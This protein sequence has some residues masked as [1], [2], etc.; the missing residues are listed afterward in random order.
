MSAIRTVNLLW[1]QRVRGLYPVSDYA[2]DNEG[3]LTLAMP[4]PLEPRAYDLTRRRLDGGVEVRWGFAVE[5]L[6]KMEVAS[7]S[8]DCLGMTSDDLYLFHAGNKSKFLAEKRIT[9]V[10]SALSGD[11]QRVAAAF[12][13]IAGASFALAYGEIGGRLTWLREFDTPLSTVAIARDGGR[14]AAGAENGNVWLLDSARRDLW[15]FLLD[16]PVRALACS[17]DGLAT[18]Y[19]T[20]GGGVGLIVGDGNRRWEARIAG[21]IVA[22]AL[23]SDGSL[24][25]ALARPHGDPSGT[26][27]IVCF[28]EDGQEGWHYETEKRLLGVALSPDGRYLATGARDGTTTVYAV[29]PGEGGAAGI[30]VGTAQ[31]RALELAQAGALAEACAVLRE[32]V[33]LQPA[34]LA[35][36]DAL[37]QSRERYFAETLTAAKGALETGDAG[38]AIRALAALL[39]EEPLHFEAVQML[40][41]AR[42]RRSEQ[43]LAEAH[44]YETK[45][46]FAAVESALREATAVAPLDQREPRQEL[47]AFLTRRTQAADAEAD[48]L[49]KAGETEAALAALERAQAVAASQERAARIV[50]AQIDLEFAEGMAAYNAKRYTEAIFQ[51]KKVLIR[52]PNHADARRYLGF[53]QKFAQDAQTDSLTDRFSR[54]E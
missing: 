28:L 39:Q 41:Q 42:R 7:A 54:L 3:A 23:S 33:G 40:L 13:D 49:L 18:A 38:G 53:A 5:T 19:G 52:D 24:C 44:V 21:E 30:A 32:A 11:G 31:A 36:C 45:E 47:A 50:R 27:W 4:R 34:D 9:Y 17:Q 14:V 29:V 43:L 26:T 25:T 22:V 15:T 12:S 16:E 37:L 6:L 1:E 2:L 35:L 8:D 10:D 46:D 20:A 48:R 51:F